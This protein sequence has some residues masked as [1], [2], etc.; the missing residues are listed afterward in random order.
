MVGLV[1]GFSF[2]SFFS[3]RIG[4][5]PPKQCEASEE[6]SCAEL[7][8]LKGQLEGVTPDEIREYLKIQTAEEKLKKADEILGKIVSALVASIGYKLHKDE[9]GQL[10]KLEIQKVVDNQPPPAPV[11]PP[12]VIGAPTAKLADS[13]PL[14]QRAINVIRIVDREDD[15][16]KFLNSLGKNYQERIQ[17]SRNLNRRQ[18]QEI[19][20]RFDGAIMFSKANRAPNR[21]SLMFRGRLTGENNSELEGRM[22]I[23]IF[24][25]RGQRRSHGQSNGNLTGKVTGLGPSVYLS[26]GGSYFELV[27]FPRL[28][29]WMGKFLEQEKG[30]FVPT[31]DVVLKRVGG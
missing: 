22:E 12:A 27:Y 18:L 17:S 14:D 10:G 13:V 30:T 5:E 9:V 28:G 4:S 6:G 7:A 2:G 21:V 1:L 8:K 25:E 24:N 23:E 29:Q 19:N 31:G 26:V 20:G 15:A 3:S 16:K 11:Q